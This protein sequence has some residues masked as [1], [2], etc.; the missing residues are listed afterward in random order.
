VRRCRR[1]LDRAERALASQ[2]EGQLLLR[3]T[4][5]PAARAVHDELTSGEGERFRPGPSGPRGR[6]RHRGYQHAEEDDERAKSQ[7]A[8]ARGA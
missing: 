1:V 6:G 3:A 8:H 7:R 4:A 2:R 5:L